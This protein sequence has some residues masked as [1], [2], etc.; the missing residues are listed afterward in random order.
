MNHQLSRFVT[1]QIRSVVA[2]QLC[3]SSDFSDLCQCRNTNVSRIF[4]DM[5]YRFLDATVQPQN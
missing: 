4:T 3:S 5:V 2:E 1:Q